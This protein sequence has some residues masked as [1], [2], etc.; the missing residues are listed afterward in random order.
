M[1]SMYSRIIPFM[2]LIALLVT[3]CA[4]T[5]AGSGPRNPLRLA[6]AAGGI[7]ASPGSTLFLSGNYRLGD[8]GL[9]VAGLPNLFWIPDGADQESARATGT[10]DLSVLRLPARWQ[11]QLD[12]ARFVYRAS[13]PA[14]D[15]YSLRVSLKLTIP[16]DA[17]PGPQVIRAALTTRSGEQQLEIPVRVRLAPLLPSR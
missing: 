1:K 3:A 16:G 2:I 12:D 10:V 5:A 9:T 7:E 8:V 4:P 11:L 6:E 15:A 14:R 17:A 13:E